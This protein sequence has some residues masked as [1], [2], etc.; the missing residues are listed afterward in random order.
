MG[1]IVTIHTR[2]YALV[3]QMVGMGPDQHGWPSRFEILRRHDQATTSSAPVV[4]LSLSGS[5]EWGM[6]SGSGRQH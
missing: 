2:K 5:P 3:P 4:P 6:K 1:R